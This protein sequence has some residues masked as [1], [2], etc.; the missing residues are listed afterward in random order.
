MSA[1]GGSVR[2]G[3]SAVGMTYGMTGSCALLY[4]VT[5]PEYNKVPIGH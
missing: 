2:H 4:A 3:E 1:T 5:F